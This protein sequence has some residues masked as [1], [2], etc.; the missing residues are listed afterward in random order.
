[1]NMLYFTLALF[2]GAALATQVALNTQL[3]AA[4]GTPMQATMIS[5]CIGAFAAFAY[6]VAARHPWPTAS[7]VS[8]SPWWGWCG[9]FLGVF[10]LW[11]TVVCAPRLGVAVTFGLVIAGQVITS[12]VLDHFGLLSVPV[13]LASVQRVI[14]VVLIVVGVVVMG[15]AK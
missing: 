13:T 12:L 10:Y 4:V 3:R 5:M 2:A 6:T 14:G 9:G 15:V 8:S 1:M 11:A 7:S